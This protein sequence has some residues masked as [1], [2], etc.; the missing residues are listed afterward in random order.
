[1]LTEL[2]RQKITHY[3]HAVLD[4]DRN[5][6]LQDND[7][8]E[9]GESLCILWRYKPGS[10]EYQKVIDQ[11]LSSWHLFERHFKTTGGE[12]NLENFLK[13]FD[14]M[15]SPGGEEMYRQYVINVVGDVFDSFDVNA[16][17]V[18]SINE[19]VDLFMCYHIKIKYSAKAFLKLD[20]NGDDQVTKEELLQAVDEFFKSDDPKAPGN[21]LFGFWGDKD[22]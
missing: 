20:R 19:Y 15:L 11:C 7:F 14:K 12:A 6:V 18:I 16:D 5:G 9:I 10:P 17:G 3:F 21:W 13:F 2:Q 22:E 4:Q 8:M 1:M